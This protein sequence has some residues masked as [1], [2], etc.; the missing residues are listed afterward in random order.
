MI[1]KVLVDSP[2]PHLDRLFDYD[3]PEALTTVTVGTRVRVPFAGRL[4]SAVVWELAETSDVKGLKAIRSAAA[5]ATFTPQAL[6]LA[7]A[8]A[9]RY[10]GS[11]WDV[12]RLM[13][14]PRVAAV[15]KLPWDEW[16]SAAAFTTPSSRVDLTSPRH[17]V[18][19]APPDAG[20]LV[21]HADLLEWVS[22]ATA[23]DKSAIVVLPDS[24]SVTSFVAAAGA[25]SLDR[26]TPRAGG[27]LVVLDADDGPR[28]RYASFLAASL[29][30][31]RIVVGTRPAAWQAVPSLGGIAV[32]DEASSTYQDPRAPYPHAR[33]VAAMRCASQD[34]LF[35]AAGRA[36]SAEAASLCA[37]GF[38]T[39]RR[40]VIDRPSTPAISVVTPEMDGRSG[41]AGWHWLPPAAAEPLG[42]AGE[43]SLGAL[44][45]PQGGYASGVACAR[46]DTWATCTTCGGD[47]AARTNGAPLTCSDCGAAHEPWFCGECTSPRWRPRGLGVERAAEQVRRMFSRLPIHVSSA[48]TGT[49]EDF[50]VTRGI[51]VATP[52]ALPQVEGGYGHLVIA[53]ARVSLAEGLGAE[54][55]SVRRWL[56]AAALVAPRSDGGG[57]TVVGDVGERVR[58]ALIAWDGWGLAQADLNERTEAGL[59]PYRRAM[60]LTGD[61]SAIAQAVEQLPKERADVAPA[62]GGAWVLA[63]RSDMQACVDAIRGAAVARSAAGL[64]PLHVRVDANPGTV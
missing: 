64:S 39:P 30:V 3:I 13:A 60:R 7:Q 19:A 41:A 63:S 14:P 21:P 31:A 25:A 12:L 22:S 56:N 20:S 5:M 48:A 10:G 17:E 44:L 52:G 2:L 29:G 49:L 54:V 46:C 62:A 36:V 1:A 24:R 23:G 28:L 32:W 43:S 50:A 38:A 61:A 18:W 58:Q 4:T 8:L 27:H 51:V 34:A 57:V 40:T 15:E 6:E 35:L 53:G 55:N 47:L 59:P 45:V 37:Y 16:L 42:R 33:T 26:W 9:H 11:R